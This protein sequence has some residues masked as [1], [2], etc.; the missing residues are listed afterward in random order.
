MWHKIPRDQ[1]VKLA[2]NV[3]AIIRH[4]INMNENILSNFMV[5]KNC[6]SH[7]NIV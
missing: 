7:N 6:L 2:K 1:Y 3:L 4:R 5:E